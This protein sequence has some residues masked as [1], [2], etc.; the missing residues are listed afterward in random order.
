MTA[1][2]AEAYVA[3][4]LGAESGRTMLAR[5]DGNRLSLHEVYRFPNGPVH[6]GK[7]LYWDVLRLWEEVKAGLARCVLQAGP[8]G[9]AALGVDTW[10][11]DFALLDRDGE[12][13]GLP[14]HYRDPRTQGM[15]EEAFRRVPREEIFAATGIQFMPI[16]TLYQLLALV[17]RRSP[18]LDAAA[19]FVTIPDLFNFWLTGRRVCE[20]TNATTTQL[21]DPRAGNWAWS[22]IERLGIP[23]RIFPQIVPP[24]TILGELAAEVAE[25][26]GSGRVPVI[27]PSCHDTGSAVAAVPVTPGEPDAAPHAYISS[28][29]WSLVGIEVRT[30]VITPRSL[31]LNFTNEGGVA[32]T[33]R[34]LKN[35]MGLWLVQECRRAW[36]RQGREYTYDA[37]IDLAARAAPLQALVDP[38]APDFLA[39]GD[40]PARLRAY[41]RATGQ[42]EPQDPGAV[43]RCALESLAL[44][45]RLVLEQLDELAGRRVEPVHIVG[46]GARNRLL[47]RFTADATGRLVL[48]GPTEA[49]ALGNVLVQAMAR[50][51]LSSLAE[52][53]E[54]VRRSFEIET[55]PPNPHAAALWNEAYVRFQRLLGETAGT[56]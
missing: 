48:A 30:P 34:L 8:G 5:F 4:D 50:G 10:G 24:G 22:L 1:A 31:A 16:N 43:V 17:V 27:A 12:L 7:S 18:L 21:Y 51:R 44:K 25:E 46:G 35:V 47:C 42:P 11:V 9:I 19:T 45:Y 55:Y 15:M 37:L 33:F 3:V 36:A 32:G 39:P 56:A 53:R 38:D 41:C 20:F 40:M 54:L 2:G 6:V 29:T 28:G 52:G 13:L 49:T 14:H 23:A 26:T